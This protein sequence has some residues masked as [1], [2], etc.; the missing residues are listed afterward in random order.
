MYPAQ[1]A[2]WKRKAL[3]GSPGLFS[4]R[5]EKDGREEDALKAR[6]YEQI[7]Q[8]KVELDWLKRRL[9]THD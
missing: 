1:I 5:G 8:L 6:F 7:G 9:G 2:A 3:E 4:D